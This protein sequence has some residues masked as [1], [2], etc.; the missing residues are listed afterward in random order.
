MMLIAERKQASRK[1]F[2]VLLGDM[3]GQI[4]LLSA[5]MIQ[6]IQK[7]SVGNLRGQAPDNTVPDEMR[8]E[9]GTA[10]S[11]RR[12]PKNR[13]EYLWCALSMVL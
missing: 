13:E 12:S 9:A 1:E 2:D 7:M 10:T 6:C 5:T 3:G 8:E 4:K 11:W